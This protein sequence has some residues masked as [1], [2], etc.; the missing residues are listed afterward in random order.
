MKAFTSGSQLA[1]LALY[2]GGKSQPGVG[3]DASRRLP[4]SQSLREQSE[5]ESARKAWGLDSHVTVL[6]HLWAE[7]WT[8]H[9][10]AELLFLWF[11]LGIPAS[12]AHVNTQSL[13]C[14]TMMKGTMMKGTMMEPLGGR[15]EPIET[16]H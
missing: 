3:K 15:T 1:V 11:E 4:I 9:R 12:G 5:G 14:G 13:A 10:T 2:P 8:C 6:L 16:G 7:P